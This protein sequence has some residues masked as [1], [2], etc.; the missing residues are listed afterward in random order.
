[1]FKRI[2]NRS[3]EEWMSCCFYEDKPYGITLEAEFS[4][5]EFSMPL[6]TEWM[7]QKP[8]ALMVAECFGDGMKKRIKLLGERLEFREEKAIILWHRYCAHSI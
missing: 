5:N 2:E 3:I 8:H 7:E 6:C 4:G 1:V